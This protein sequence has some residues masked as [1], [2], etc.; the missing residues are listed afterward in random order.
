M[1]REMYLES[2]NAILSNGVYHIKCEF[3]DETEKQFKSN[4]LF[5]GICQHNA[6]MYKTLGITQDD[7]SK[8][9]DINSEDGIF[10]TST[11]TDDDGNFVLIHLTAACDLYVCKSDLLSECYAGLSKWLYRFQE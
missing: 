4:Y 2:S 5:E 10:F 3:S 11:Y 1:F 8:C 7:Y 6:Y 9:I